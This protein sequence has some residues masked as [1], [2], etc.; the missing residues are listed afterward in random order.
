MGV[1]PHDYQLCFPDPPLRT[2]CN[3]PLLSKQKLNFRKGCGDPQSP[4]TLALEIKG[5]I[6]SLLY[7]ELKKKNFTAPLLL[8][9]TENKY[10]ILKS[11]KKMP[12][13]G[14]PRCQ[15]LSRTKP[16]VCSWDF[17]GTSL[18]FSRRQSHS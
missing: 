8:K 4:L 1:C 17:K 9:T 10:R 6:D 16:R 14:E 12:R 11:L 18:V 3:L 13:S 5:R 7:L 2:W 15:S